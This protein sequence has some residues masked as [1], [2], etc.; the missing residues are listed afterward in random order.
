MDKIFVIGDV[1]GC[2]HTLTELLKEWDSTTEQ[3]IFIGDLIDRGN[4]SPQVVQLV[5]QLCKENDA[6]C[7]MGNHE[8]TCAKTILDLK[9]KDWYNG[10]GAEVIA[11]YQKAGLRIKNDAK[12]FKTLSLLWQNESFMISH[13]GISSKTN[14]P[15]DVEDRESMLYT[16]SPLKNIEGKI[17]VYG[18]TPN[19]SNPKYNAVSNAWNIDSAAVYGCTLSGLK[20]ESKGKLLSQHKI[21]TL[22]KD[23]PKKPY[24]L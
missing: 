18:H 6:V 20:F 16:R 14:N 8:Y 7:L 4:F 10:M 24:K 17:Q 5:K 3:L 22:A 19:A 13:A 21:K 11:Q 1:H 12:W 2:Y 15:F 9:Q 23:L